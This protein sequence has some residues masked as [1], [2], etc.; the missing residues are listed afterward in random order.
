MFF[1]N[2]QYHI[3]KM[4]E[5]AAKSSDYLITRTQNVAFYLF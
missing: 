2:R 1:F 3:L 4:L 5:T